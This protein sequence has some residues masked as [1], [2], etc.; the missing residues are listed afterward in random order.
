MKGRGASSEANS[1]VT[2][3]QGE[4]SLSS[5]STSVEVRSLAQGSGDRSHVVGPHDI[6]HVVGP[7]GTVS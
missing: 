3:G 6:V 7:H 2:C 5:L 4:L 1:Q